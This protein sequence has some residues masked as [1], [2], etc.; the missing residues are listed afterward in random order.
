VFELPQASYN[1]LPNPQ[2]LVE[3]THTF[4]LSVS[5]N[6]GTGSSDSFSIEIKNEPSPVAVTNLQIDDPYNAF[7]HIQ[8]SWNEGVLVRNDFALAAGTDYNGDG[9]DDTHSYTGILNN[10]LYFKVYMNGVEKATYQNSVG[11]GAT[12]THHEESL[13][14]DTDH[15]FVVEAFNSDDEGGANDDASHHT[16][17]RPTVTVVT[18]NG[19]EIASETDLYNVEF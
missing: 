6:Y 17:A 10:T 11:D 8:I 9:T 15:K 3:G 5:D 4:T 7:K 12:Y 1:T 19:L 16:H 13:P 18:P 14:A 2:E